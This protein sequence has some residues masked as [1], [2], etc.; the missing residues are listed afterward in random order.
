MCNEV[1]HCAPWH[2]QRVFIR[3]DRPWWRSSFP[4]ACISAF[5]SRS[6]TP[7]RRCGHNSPRIIPYS[8]SR[9]LCCLAHAD[10]RRRAR[11]AAVFARDA[12]RRRQLQVAERA[13]RGPLHRVQKTEQP[14]SGATTAESACGL[15]KTSSRP[16]RRRRSRAARASRRRHKYPAHAAHHPTSSRPTRRC[17]ERAPAAATPPACP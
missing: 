5:C 12:S 6:D 15:R 13:A 9:A 14:T 17:S 1:G 16:T 7:Q 8:G 11:L 3:Q 2:L 10:H 4:A